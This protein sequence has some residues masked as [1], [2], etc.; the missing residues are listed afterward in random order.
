MFGACPWDPVPLLPC[1]E[2]AVA[3]NPPLK[4]NNSLDMG[5][6]HWKKINAKLYGGK[7]AFLYL[8]SVLPMKTDESLKNDQ[9]LLS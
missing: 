3:M 6:E 4:E 8:Q 9:W 5:T 1:I 2:D 7:S